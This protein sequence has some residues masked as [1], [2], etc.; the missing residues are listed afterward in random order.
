MPDITTIVLKLETSKAN[1]KS[2]TKDIYL[3]EKV[4]YFVI[5]HKRGKREQCQ[6]HEESRAGV[7]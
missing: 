6:Q 4:F 1:A 3:S 7:L 5:L 2:Q